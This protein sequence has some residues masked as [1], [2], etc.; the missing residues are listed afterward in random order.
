L[1]L[2]PVKLGKKVTLQYIPFSE[3]VI[4]WDINVDDDAAAHDQG[5]GWASNTPGALALAS[6]TGMP[7]TL[8]SLKALKQQGL[9]GLKRSIGRFG[10]L[11][12]LE[13]AALPEELSF[14]F[15]KGKYAVMDGQRR[16]FAMR[17]L[18]RLPTEQDERR[19]HGSLRTHTDNPHLAKAEIQAQEH[20]KRL[21]IRD[22][23]LVPCLVY[24]YTTYL[25]MMRHSIE[26]NSVSA[27]A[28]KIFREIVEQMLQKGI[29]DLAP[30]DLTS[31]WNTRTTLTEEQQAIEHTLREIRT[32]RNGTPT[33]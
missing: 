31:L 21:S 4:P 25:Q 18:L 9:D 14:F 13:V 8:D 19:E 2:E 20:L 28:S 30:D 15:G 33:P 1:S 6:E 5:G 10:L 16:Y 11:K 3:L 23:V 17:E 29:S 27:N 26:G 24:P 22:Y 32:R 7:T 12:P